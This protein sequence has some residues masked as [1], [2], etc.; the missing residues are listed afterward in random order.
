MV[1]LRHRHTFLSSDQFFRKLFSLQSFLLWQD[2]G[3][4]DRQQDVQ[5]DSEQD[6]QQAAQDQPQDQPA[7]PGRGAGATATHR[8]VHRLPAYCQGCGSGSAFIHSFL[9][10]DPGGKICKITSPKNAKKYLKISISGIIFEK[11]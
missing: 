11:R 7:Q 10:S 8:S 4:G 6:P 5:Q 3:G 1:S 9:D 2:E